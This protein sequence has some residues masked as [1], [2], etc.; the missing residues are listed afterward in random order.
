MEIPV[1]FQRGFQ[2]FIVFFAD[3]HAKFS[4]NFSPHFI[5]LAAFQSRWFSEMHEIWLSG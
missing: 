3:S 4:R 1:T 2:D 5:G